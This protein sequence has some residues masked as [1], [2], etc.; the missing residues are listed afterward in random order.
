M[1]Q[2]K[3][4]RRS[5][6][7]EAES[8]EYETRQG[9]VLEEIIYT[10]LLIPTYSYDPN[11]P[12]VWDQQTG[13]YVHRR[14]TGQTAQRIARFLLSLDEESAIKLA[15][16]HAQRME[17]ERDAARVAEKDAAAKAE[18]LASEAENVIANTERWRAAAHRHSLAYDKAQEQLRK[19]EGD[20]AR[21]QKAIGSV[22]YQKAL[23]S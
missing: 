15:A 17:N 16:E 23:E 4:P 3:A 1:M 11:A 7:V 2:P 6:I 22:A 14:V 13:T 9:W 18:K 8:L 5:K 10:D 19:L 21:I 12:Q 20:L